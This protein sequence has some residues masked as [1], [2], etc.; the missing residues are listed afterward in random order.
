MMGICTY[1]ILSVDF[2]YIT[3]F[4]ACGSAQARNGPEEQATPRP[5]YYS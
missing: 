4:I 3:I 1:F 2:F 5:V